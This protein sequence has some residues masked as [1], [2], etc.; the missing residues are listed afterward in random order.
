MNS[1]R[2]TK[3]AMV[4]IALSRFQGKTV[5]I[6]EAAAIQAYMFLINRRQELAFN[7][8]INEAI[9]NARVK[10]YLEESNTR[11]VAGVMNE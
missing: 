5:T 11:L 3:A 2:K 4:R 9:R 6:G 10:A 8:A 7:E 1:A